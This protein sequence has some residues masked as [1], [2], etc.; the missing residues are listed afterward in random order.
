LKKVTVEA[1]ASSANLG[2]GFDAFALALDRPRDRVSLSSEPAQRL[3]VEVENA[4]ELRTPTSVARNAAGAVC[5]AM[6]RDFRIA[7]T[8]IGLEIAKGVP[9][10]VGMG[11][12]GAS[13]AA[14]AFAMNERFGLRLSGDGMIFY[15]GVG[16]RAASGA[17]HYDNV[18]ASVLGGF[19]VV[20]VAERPCAIS[21]GPPP[22]LV[23]VLV[24][25]VLDLPE[26]KTE[27]TRSVL[28]RTVELK[29][30]VSNVASAS[31]VV[32]G[33]ARGDIAMI[34]R[35]MM[36]DVVVEEARKRLIPG[37]E[38]VRRHAVAAGAAGVCIS[39]AGPSMLA[40]L[41]GSS[42]DPRAVMDNMVAGFGEEGVESDGFVT[43]VG[44]GAA[45]V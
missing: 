21:Y 17:A 37:Y 12:S 36:G 23:L 20:S 10:G 15:A 25:P 30:M 3:S 24:T 6:A 42:Q 8:R 1:P 26:R 16:E 32:S 43:R 35:G 39:G 40:L 34:G 41:D 33:F 22:G 44:A 9:I 29:K 13:A 19:A 38:S 4:G 5:L 7:G 27:Y 31:M 14:A 28:P 2:P 45:R 11:S 18:A